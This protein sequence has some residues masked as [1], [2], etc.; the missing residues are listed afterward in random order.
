MFEAY[1][2]MIAFF[3]IVFGFMIYRVIISIKKPPQIL[4]DDYNRD[5]IP[6]RVWSSKTRYIDFIFVK[7]DNGKYRMKIKI[8]VILALAASIIQLVFGLFV[9][10][11]CKDEFIKNSYVMP[12]V[13]AIVIWLFSNIIFV[14][15][16]PIEAGICFRKAMKK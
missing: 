3:I 4:T 11:C 7:R 12:A 6:I 9:L 10:Y 13:I 15:Y 16:S 2:F 14:L 1:L 5:E 8:R